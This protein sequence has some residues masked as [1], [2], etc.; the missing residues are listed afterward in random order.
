M[1]GEGYSG[2]T[3]EPAVAER[4]GLRREYLYRCNACAVEL[5]YVARLLDWQLLPGCHAALINRCRGRLEL[6]DSRVREAAP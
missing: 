2:Y 3:P 5:W 1:G 6:V 4:K